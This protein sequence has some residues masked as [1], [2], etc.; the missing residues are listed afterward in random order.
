MAQ[1]PGTFEA[2]A[3]E[4]RRAV[5]AAASGLGAARVLDTFGEFGVQF[6][7]QL[8]TDAGVTA[9]RGAVVTAGSRLGDQIQALETAIEAGSGGDIV[10]GALALATTVGQLID[11]FTPLPR[12]LQAALPGLPGITAGQ[13]NTLVGDLPER[14][15]DLLVFD[16]ID[17]VP[18]VGA[19]LQMFG[20]VERTYVAGDPNDHTKPDFERIELHLDR[21]FP[22]ITN[23]VAQ[24]ESLY[25][26]GQPAFD[27]T[28]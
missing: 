9:A 7:P 18:A 25:Q 23:P 27:A 2:L 8:L 24:L 22:S 10:A 3:P 12:A 26:W 13:V 17:A 4:I 15:L 11:A 21:L 28:A 20:V 16:A 6:P 5:G 1:Q 19:V 14:L